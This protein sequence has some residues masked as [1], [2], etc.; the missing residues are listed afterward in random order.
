MKHVT[1]DIVPLEIYLSETIENKTKDL[2]FKDFTL[3]GS[4]EKKIKI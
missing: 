2:T 1:K 4:H 3:M